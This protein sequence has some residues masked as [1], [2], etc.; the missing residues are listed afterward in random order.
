VRKAHPGRTDNSSSRWK[1]T[2][3]PPAIGRPSGVVCATTPTMSKTTRRGG[4]RNAIGIRWPRRLPLNT[5]SPQHL[6]RQM[7]RMR[8]VL[9]SDS[10]TRWLERLRRF[11]IAGAQYGTSIARE[12]ARVGEGV[13][14][15]PEKGKMIGEG[16]M[17]AAVGRLDR[18]DGRQSCTY[19]AHHRSRSSGVRTGFLPGPETFKHAGIEPS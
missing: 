1:I 18:P 7:M 8:C 16:R 15:A 9:M 17:S 19:L 4:V 13:F 3:A 10:K 2:C 5:L 12:L 11:R 14:F 6:R